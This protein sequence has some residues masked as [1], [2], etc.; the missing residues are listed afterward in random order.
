[1]KIKDLIK[2]GKELYPTKR[3]MRKQWVKQT[4]YLYATGKHA[5]ITGGWQNGNG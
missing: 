2:R 3:A 4:L 5:L 1:M